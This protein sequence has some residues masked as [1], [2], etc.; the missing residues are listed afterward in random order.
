MKILYLDTSS[1]YLYSA[2]WQNGEILESINQQLDKDLSVF[3]LPKIS[4]MLSKC[5]I[6]PQN[7]DKIIVVNGP[8]SF[9][10]IR[11]GVTDA[12]VYA[13]GLKKDI[14]TIYSLQA[15]ATSSEKDVEYYI[16]VIDARRGYVYAAVYDKNNVPIVK[17]QYTSIN[18]LKCVLESLPGDYQVITND[19]LDFDNIEKY[20][21]NFKKII[22]RYKD[23]ETENPHS[24]NPVYLKLTEAE[25]KKS[26]EII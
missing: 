24:V 18:A 5:N 20:N 4:E 15:M 13:Y 6:E 1:N 8:G 12:K 17:E 21:P 9:T 25:E 19:N 22:D 26:V 16:P 2:I 3:T 23:K 14:A 7:I 11:V 10:G